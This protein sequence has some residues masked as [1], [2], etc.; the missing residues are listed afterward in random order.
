MKAE[1]ESGQPGVA[2]LFGHSSA[3]PWPESAVSVKNAYALQMLMGN[4]SAF[5]CR[6]PPEADTFL[7]CCLK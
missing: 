2:L 7:F 5:A 6:H 4:A 3:K 1:D